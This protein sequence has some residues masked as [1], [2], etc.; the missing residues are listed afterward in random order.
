MKE[1][2]AIQEPLANP[3]CAEQQ[4]EAS[5]RRI[6]GNKVFSIVLFYDLILE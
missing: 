6:S 1:R 3:K 4:I 5:I 2:E